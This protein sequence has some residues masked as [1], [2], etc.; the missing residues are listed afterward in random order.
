MT[1]G[2]GDLRDVL[3]FQRRRVGKADQYG[4]V[5]YEWQDLTGRVAA[6]VKPYGGGEATF[7]ARLQ[8]TTGYRV[9][10]R[11]ERALAGLMA[12]DRA[13]DARNPARV[14]NIKSIQPSDSN[15]WIDIAADYGEAT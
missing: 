13:I 14:F 8:G 1:T 3:I 4:V 11:R 12:S 9:R 2:A 5:Q 7:Q 15:D 10:V 6:S